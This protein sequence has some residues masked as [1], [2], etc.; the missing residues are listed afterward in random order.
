MG[1][2]H[3]A[4]T[5]EGVPHWVTPGDVRR[6]AER[7]GISGIIEGEIYRLLFTQGFL[8]VSSMIFLPYS[9]FGQYRWHPVRKCF[10]RVSICTRS[11]T[12]GPS[13]EQ[14]ANFCHTYSHRRI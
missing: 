4:I 10:D 2:K 14:R 12:S 6:M 11:K 9:S 3:R 7:S 13:P 5:V 8:M 1:T